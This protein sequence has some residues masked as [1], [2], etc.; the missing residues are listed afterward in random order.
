LQSTP[1][2]AFKEPQCATSSSTRRRPH[3]DETSFFPVEIKQTSSE[4]RFHRSS[5]SYLWG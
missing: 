1:S 4:L 2:C 3:K 5:C